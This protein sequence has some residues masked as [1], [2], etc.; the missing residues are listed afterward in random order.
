[1]FQTTN[2]FMFYLFLKDFL[3]ISLFFAKLPMISAPKTCTSH[4]NSSSP[5]AGFAAPLVERI[6]PWQQNPESER[7]SKRVLS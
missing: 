6:F 7:D 2:Q 1:M 3:P 5:A 4:S